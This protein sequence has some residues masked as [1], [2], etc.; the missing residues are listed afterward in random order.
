LFAPLPYTVIIKKK[1]KGETMLN[2]LLIIVFIIFAAGVL[3][4][5]WVKETIDGEDDEW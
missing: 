5:W 4:G 1:E 2:V 3:M